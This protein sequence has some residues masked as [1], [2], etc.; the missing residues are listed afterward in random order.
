MHVLHVVGA[1]PNFMKAAPVMRALGDRARQTLVHTGQHYDR[2]MSEAFFGELGLPEPDVNL[3]VGSDTASVQTGRILVRLDPLFDRYRPDVCVVYGDVNSTLAGALAAARRQ[4]PVAHVE[5]GLRSY[6]R[7]MPEELNRELTDRVAEWLFTP[8][9]DADE[10]LVREGIPTTR[11]HRVGNVMIDTLMRLL[12]RADTGA[13]RQRL[14]IPAGAPYVL[15]TL[16]RPSTVDDP[17]VF[18][19]ILGVLAELAARLPVV[20]PV[21]PRSRA[22]LDA[23][24]WSTSGLRLADPMRYLDFLALEREAAV[25]VTDSGGV[26]EETTWLK[27]PCLTFRDNTERPVTVLEGTNT[28]V[29]RDPD[30][31]RDALR[32]T[33]D[34]ERP[35][36]QRPALWDGHAA[37]RIAQVLSRT[38]PVPPRAAG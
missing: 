13:V 21:H 34:G 15:V 22:R 23:G 5:A 2:E 25:V 17:Q 20:F 36:A 30:R 37:A 31:L 29:G 4:V 27:V 8:S 19:G 18:E 6:D 3:A 7:T 28:L 33:L 38:S 9:L 16:H 11:I 35:A 14:G 1:R 26:Q 12:P 24:R 32:A 10:N